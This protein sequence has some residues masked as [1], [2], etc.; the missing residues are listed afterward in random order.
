MIMKKN[1]LGLLVILLITVAGC[2]KKEETPVEIPQGTFAGSFT[3]LHY[4]VA[5]NKMDT[6]KANLVI[7]FSTTTGYAVLSDTS[8]V[9]AGSKGGYSVD[10][11]YIEF[12]N[13]T[14]PAGPVPTTGKV[15]LAGIY[16]YVYT[17]N[18]LKFA[19]SNDTLGYYYDLTLAQ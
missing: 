10:P 11:Y 2:V 19:K 6:L 4:S 9:H 7:K 17:A 3:R 14:I 13:T 1:L 18:S 12:G 8:V 15:H 5:T 16:E